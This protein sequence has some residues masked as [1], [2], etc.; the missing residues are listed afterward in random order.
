MA[1]DRRTKR[2]NFFYQVLILIPNPI[3]ERG[4][5]LSLSLVKDSTTKYYHFGNIQIL[6]ETH[7]N[8]SFIQY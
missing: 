4:A 7:S 3:Y 1:K 6:E 5:L 2:E 8:H